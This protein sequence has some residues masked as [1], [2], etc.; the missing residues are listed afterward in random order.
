M[1]V[2]YDGNAILELEKVRICCVVH[3]YQLRQ[4]PVD[5]PQVLD[6]HALC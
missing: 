5:N 1:V 6:K 2:R 3:Q 4:W